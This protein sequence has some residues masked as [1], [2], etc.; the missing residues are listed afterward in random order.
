M[1]TPNTMPLF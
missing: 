1:M